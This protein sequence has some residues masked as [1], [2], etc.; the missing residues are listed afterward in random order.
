MGEGA[1]GVPGSARVHQ[2]GGMSSPDPYNLQ[3]FVSAQSGGV[4]EQAL[5]E[6]RAG[7]KTSHWMWFIFPQ[8][9][10]LGRSATAVRY[11]ISGMDEARAYA[12]HPVLGPR[13]REASAAVLDAPA[14]TAADLLGG[15]DATKLRSSMTLFELADPDEP[16]YGRVLERYYTGERDHSTLDLL[17]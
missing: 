2:T 15:I 17:H 13:L 1:A 7:H 5:A 11:A 14:A 6:L 10:G 8:L 9:A 12:G 4:Y 16:V 3:R